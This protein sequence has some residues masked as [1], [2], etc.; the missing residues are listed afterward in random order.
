[1]GRQIISWAN[2]RKEKKQEQAQLF[3]TKLIRLA[4]KQLKLQWMS[5]WIKPKQRMCF[6]CCC[7]DGLTSNGSPFFNFFTSA[8]R[9][10]LMNT[11]TSDTWWPDSFLES[12]LYVKTEGELV[13]VISESW[14]SSS[15]V[16][17]TQI[18][19]CLACH[20]LLQG[21]FN[22]L[23]W[24]PFQARSAVTSEVYVATYLPG[25]LTTH[26]KQDVQAPWCCWRESEVE[27]RE[28]GLQLP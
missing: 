25:H 11:G 19:H 14:S 2:T 20:S 9:L 18:A 6:V 22:P 16:K 4:W 1:M 12:D 10:R 24:W 8:I 23:L 3:T 5:N 17:L 28:N 27:R 21:T 15:S 7:C 13:K 26:F